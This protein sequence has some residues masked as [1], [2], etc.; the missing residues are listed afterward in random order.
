M[1]VLDQIKNLK[2]QLG[3]VQEVLTRDNLKDWERKEYEKLQG[4][5]ISEIAKL[6]K[7]VKENEAIFYQ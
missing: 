3:Y 5:Y 7:H 2:G 1:N 6:E 4:M